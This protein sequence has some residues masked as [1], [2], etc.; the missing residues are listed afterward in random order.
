MK[1]IEEEKEK[2]VEVNPFEDYEL[3]DHSTTDHEHFY[4]VDPVQDKNS[5]LLN[6]MC[7]GCPSGIMIDGDKFNVVD[8]KIITKDKNA[9]NLQKEL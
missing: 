7:T 8:G 3:K 1:N 2:E 5:E 6:V 9:K 4:V